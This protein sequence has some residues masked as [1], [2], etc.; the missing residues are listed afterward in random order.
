[1]RVILRSLA[2]PPLPLF[3]LST[4]L[5]CPALP[6]ALAPALI[7]FTL[8]VFRLTTHYILK[9]TP[10]RLYRGELIANLCPC[11]SQMPKLTSQGDFEL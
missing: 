3:I 9:L 5:F 1:M 6:S 4:V 8:H 11:V 10:Q 2:S 7:S